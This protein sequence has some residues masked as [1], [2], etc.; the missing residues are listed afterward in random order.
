[1]KKMS[2][3]L[4]LLCH[5]A[6]MT[7]AQKTES[8]YLSG[9]GNDDTVLW[10]F[11]CSAGRNSGVWTKIAVPSNWE[12][13][14]F[15]QFNYGHD[16]ERLN[17]YGIYRYEFDIPRHWIDKK[18]NIVFE[19]SMTDTQV[20]INGKEAG[21]IHQGGFYEFR[22][23]ITRL[24]KFGKKNLLEVTVHK[25]SAN[26]SIENGERNSDFWVFGGIYRPVWLEALPKT[27]I[28]RIAI[29]AKGDGS[30]HADIFLGGD[31]SETQLKAQ[32]KTLDGK[33]A[34]NPVTGTAGKVSRVRLSGVMEN[35]ALWSSESP[36][37]YQLELSLYQKGQLLHVVTSKFGFRTVEM[38]PGDGFYVNGTK[39][40]FKG[41]NR[42]S[43]WPTSGRAT[44]RNI[45][46]A[47][48]ELIK[49][50]NMN[51]VRMSHYPPDKHFLDVCDSLG[52]YVIDELTGWQ[53][54][55]DTEAGR[56]LVKEL[57]VR[58]LNHPSVVMWANGNEGG[59]NFELVPEYARYDIQ[60]RYVFHPWLDEENS[61]TH[62]Y[63]D[64]KVAFQLF[65]SGKKVFF[66]TE[67]MHGLYDGGHGAGLDDFWNLMQ[68][69][70][71]SA[72]GFL[73]DLADQGVVRD[74][75]NGEIDTD[76]NHAADGIVGP[77][78]EKEGSFYTIKEIFSPVY[79]EGPDF[80]PPSFDGKIRVHN[81][82]H[83][84]NL[85]AC[86]FLARWVRFDFITGKSHELVSQ[87]DAPDVMPGYSGELRVELPERVSDY[88]LLLI[89]AVD[90]YGKEIYTWSRNITRAE[91]FAPRLV[92]PGD[93]ETTVDELQETFILTSGDTKV[94]I[95]KATGTI[96]EITV[97][98]KTVALDNGPRFTGGELIP[99][100]IEQIVEGATSRVKISFNDKNGR[101]MNRSQ[102]TIGLLP[103]GWIEVD[104]QFDVGGYHDHIGVT[105]NYPEEKV[106]GVRWLGNGPYRVWKNRLKGVRFNI[107]EKEYNNTVTG[108]SWIYPEFK[109]FHSNVYAADLFTHEG[110]VKFVIASDH[111]FLHLFTPD[112][113]QRRNN[114]NTLGIFPDGQLSVLNA[115]SP[116]GTK[117]QQARELGPQS[118]QSYLLS[119]G[120]LQP[121]GGKFYIRYNPY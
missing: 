27:H 56:R 2:L 37:L 40:K 81:R 86:K 12:F 38:R 47:D 102:I 22:Y 5:M 43:H 90:H 36:N 46:I 110:V 65:A 24:L 63:P 121:P 21:E 35:P 85:K 59:F 89:T 48:V 49:E 11:F 68:E 26:E 67:F 97:N 3:S 18:I 72:G 80:L 25:S 76:G 92:E 9:T 44:N 60:N 82:Y 79:L 23:D 62:H 32:V 15:G 58:D 95:E 64:W 118:Q 113:P 70:P 53:S 7:F 20:R 109:G 104:Y 31:F 13:E 69:H 17:E 4:L 33:P 91:D 96:S 116:V 115:I 78:R 77:F 99:G 73:W 98:G 71:L 1:M 106:K 52:L 107:W 57:V 45:S 101:K 42:H 93:G 105:F 54:K 75:R 117:F 41:V 14:G 10:D 28:E 100:A 55:Y 61:N 112:N 111:L 6:L 19:G 16:K 108:E 87:I 50:M 29:D 66:P 39:I 114:D 103:S 83:F 94:R 51:A 88:D 119:R 84:T 30:F 74:D 120:H 34:G 8:L